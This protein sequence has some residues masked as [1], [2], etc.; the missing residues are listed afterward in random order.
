MFK[1]VLRNKSERENGGEGLVVEGILPRFTQRNVLLK[2]YRDFSF[3]E[4]EEND[5]FDAT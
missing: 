1:K 5:L 2:F 3:H 4:T